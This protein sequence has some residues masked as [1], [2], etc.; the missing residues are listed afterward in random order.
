[1]G[2]INQPKVG[3]TLERVQQ[4]SKSSVMNM[5]DPNLVFTEPA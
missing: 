4:R 2:C 5:N 1:M 3:D